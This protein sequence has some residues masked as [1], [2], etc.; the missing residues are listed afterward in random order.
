VRRSHFPHAREIFV[1]LYGFNVTASTTPM[2]KTF[3]RFADARG[4][5]ANARLAA[6]SGGS[7]AESV[8]RDAKV[9]A[10][11]VGP[12]L[13][14][15]SEIRQV[16]RATLHSRFAKPTKD[17]MSSA[18]KRTPATAE[19][20][21]EEH[22][23]AE[24][25]ASAVC[26]VASTTKRIRIEPSS[27]EVIVD[28]DTPA[29]QSLPLGEPPALAAAD[30]DARAAHL[31]QSVV[32]SRRSRR[33]VTADAPSAADGASAAACMSA[34]E[35]ASAAACT[36]AAEGARA[37]EDGQPLLE[38][39]CWEEPPLR[40]YVRGAGYLH[41][42]IKVP[43]DRPLLELFAVQLVDLDAPTH[44]PGATAALLAGGGLLP[45]AW[46]RF[47]VSIYF[48]NPAPPRS[49][50]RRDEPTPHALLCHFASATRPADATGKGAV[51]L[52]QARAR[53][54]CR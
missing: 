30:A 17:E 6:E 18:M 7:P 9:E 1:W 41:D 29:V 46:A 13:R 35:G 20:I 2:I 54:P 53:P 3:S 27:I 43:S 28:E 47:V 38:R 21:A 45:P 32:R 12:M 52:R 34:S 24:L 8:I 33:A 42:Q 37:A 19:I 39:A 36:R 26:T 48:M 4:G 49:G 11:T 25:S 14:R 16:L 31:I 50:S 40:E 15:R 5:C 23:L 51:L 10:S 22:V 44:V